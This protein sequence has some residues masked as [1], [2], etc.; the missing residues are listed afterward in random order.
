MKES[1]NKERIPIEKERKNCKTK[2][3][4]IGRHERRREKKRGDKRLEIS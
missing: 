4:E 2:I 3:I 1:V